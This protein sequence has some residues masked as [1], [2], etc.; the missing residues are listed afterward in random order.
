MT[1]DEFLYHIHGHHQSC[2]LEIERSNSVGYQ[3]YT[4]AQQD[5]NIPSQ[6]D[7]TDK[8][9]TSYVTEVKNQQHCGMCTIFT[10]IYRHYTYF[11]YSF[12]QI[13]C[14]SFFFWF[15]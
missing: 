5:S 3:M 1:S 4:S 15:L 14:I 6:I 8:N 7:W 2:L 9:G 12:L 10:T 13:V 11:L